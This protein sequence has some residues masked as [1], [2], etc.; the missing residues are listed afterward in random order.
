MSVTPEQFEYYMAHK[1]DDR[2]PNE[3]AAGVCGLVLAFAALG[4]RI[5]ARL[6]SR[7]KFGTDDWLICIG[8]VVDTQPQGASTLLTVS[9]ARGHWIFDFH[10]SLGRKW[11]GT[12]YHLREEPAGLYSGGFNVGPGSWP[13]QRVCRF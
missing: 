7:A 9:I 11:R 2:R 1:E 12:A 8:M 13:A 5:V 10:V 3:I 4:A 6:K